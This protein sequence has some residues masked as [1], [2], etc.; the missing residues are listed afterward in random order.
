M[1]NEARAMTTVTLRSAAVQKGYERREYPDPEQRQQEQ[2]IVP[3][4]DFEHQADRADGSDYGCN[5]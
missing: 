2:G 4:A 5:S 3:V 1:A